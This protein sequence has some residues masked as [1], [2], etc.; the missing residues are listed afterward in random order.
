MASVLCHPSRRWWPTTA[1]RYSLEG[2]DPAEL[3]RSLILAKEAGWL[4]DV[5]WLSGPASAAAIYELASAL[6]SGELKRLLGRPG[7]P[8]PAGGR[9]GDLRGPGHPARGGAPGGPSPARPCEPGS[10]SPWTSPIGAGARADGLAL[11]L[12]SRRELSREWLATPSTGR[13]PPLVV[14]PRDSSSARRA[15][16]LTGRPKATMVPPGSSTSPSSATPGSASWPTASRWSGATWRPRAGCCRTPR[17][18]FEEEIDTSPQPRARRDRVAPGGGVV[19]GEHRLQRRGVRW[20]VVGSCS[21][22]TSP[23][24]TPGS[25]RP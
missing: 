14:S 4:D 18:E 10:R 25:A 5:D 19:G 3:E 22:R 9:R 8:P 16:L 2:L 15:R 21:R 6:P 13:A 1:A 24:G 23:S 11:A 17:P 7:P 20:R 12:I